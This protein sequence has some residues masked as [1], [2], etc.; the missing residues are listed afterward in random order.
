MMDREIM[1]DE[2]WPADCYLLNWICARVASDDGPKF[3]TPQIA[4]FYRSPKI[5]HDVKN[6]GARLSNHS[7]S[8][9]LPLLL[10]FDTTL[11]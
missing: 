10:L 7:P 11:F 5:W 1:L 6:H 4:A 2:D 8:Q 3:W 9:F